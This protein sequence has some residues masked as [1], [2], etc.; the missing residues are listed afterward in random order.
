M[1]VLGFQSYSKRRPSRCHRTLDSTL[2][3]AASATLRP[4]SNVAAQQPPSSISTPSGGSGQNRRP[5]WLVPAPQAIHLPIQP[6]CR[7]SAAEPTASLFRIAA[8]AAARVSP[9]LASVVPFPIILFWPFLF[10]GAIV[11]RFF[12]FLLPVFLRSPDVLT[13]TSQRQKHFDNAAGRILQVDHLHPPARRHDIV[14][15]GDGVLDGRR[16]EEEG[17]AAPRSY[18]DRDD[19]ADRGHNRHLQT[20]RRK[21]LIL[22]SRGRH[23]R[24]DSH[25]WP[26]GES[27]PDLALDRILRG[28]KPGSGSDRKPSVR[29][30]LTP[31]KKSKGDHIQVTETKGTRKASL[32]RRIPLDEA[33]ASREIQLGGEGGE[34]A[35]S[36]TSYASATEESNVS[37]NPIDIEI[38]RNRRRR[39]PASPLIP[40][41][42]TYQPGNPSEISAIPTDSF[43]DGSGP[44]GELKRS[45]SP[46]RVGDGIAAAAAGA[47]AGVAMGEISSN[48]PR[49]KERVKISDSSAK[50][51]SSDRKRRSKSRTSSVSEPVADEI[52]SSRRRS[53]RGHQ[54]STVSAADSSVLS[55]NLSPSH[56]SFDTRS[57]R[58]G[59][60]KSSIN[61]PKLLET[62]EDAIRRLIL[63]ELS[64]LKREQSKREARRGSLTS[65]GTSASRDDVSTDRRRSSGGHRSEH[66]RDPSRHKERRNREARHD[67]DETSLRSASHDSIDAEYRA[68]DGDATTPKRSNN[69]LKVAAAGAAGAAAAKALSSAMDD[70]TDSPDRTQR[71]RRRRRAESARSR[72]LGRDRYSEEYDDED[73]EMAP[74]PPMPLMSDINPSELTRTSILSA[75]TDRPHS[76]SEELV[77]GH[78]AARGLDSPGSTPT[79]ARTPADLQHTLGTKH[80]N[81]S[82]GDLNALP[83]G[84]KGYVQEY[85]TDEFGRK[86][87]IGDYD[88]Y[89]RSRNMPEVDDYPEDDF[90]DRYYSQQDVPP[91]LKYVPYQA[92][93]RGLSP[94]PSVSGYTEGGS[95]AP[96]P[97]SS[98][99]VH[100]PNALPSPGKSPEHGR[101]VR[102]AHS[103]DSVPSNMRSR[104]FDRASGHS[105]NE[106]TAAGQAVRG[107]GANPDFVHPPSGVESA[108]ASLVDGSMLEQ[109]VMTTGSGYDYSGQRDSTIS[110][111]LHSKVDRSSRGISPDKMST[112]S[113]H[114]AGEDMRAATPGSR[115]QAQSQDYSEYD[116]DEHGR[117][118]PRTRYRHSPTASEA[119]ITAG[120]RQA[121]VEDSA[122][123]AF[124]P[125]GVSRNKSFKERTTQHGW[126]PRNT[127]THSVDRL[128]FED[129]PKMAASGIPDMNSPM[130]EIGYMDDDLQTNPSVVEERL[131][132]HRDEH[133][134]SGRATPTQRDIGG[135]DHDG[136]DKGGGLG[137][138]EVAGAAALGAA[139]GM[140]AM[141]HDEPDELDE[142]Q[143]TSEERK[144]DTLVTNPYEDASPI[145]N[146][147]LDET[148]LSGRGLDAQFHTGSPGFGQKY[149]EGYMSNGPV[150]TP[151][152]EPKGK[153]IDFG[154]G[155][156]LGDDP[157]YSPQGHSRHLSGMS[158]GMA[159]PFYDA[160]TGAGIERI[161]NKDIVAL[162]Q[163][164]MVRDAQRSARD[165]EIVALLMN[166]ALEMRNSFRE[167]KELVQDTGD[168]VIFANVENT[169]K[170]Q[171]AIN[172]PRPYPGAA[173]RSIQ[174][175]SQAGTIDDVAA[176]KKNLW[177]RALQ[178]LG[179]KGTSDLSRIEDM[180]PAAA[181]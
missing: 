126:E 112:D 13:S 90:E 21:V 59:A 97:L 169:E 179:A 167:M 78:D 76:A 141:H 3:R 53:S 173:S 10:R 45:A 7:S 42:E 54:E 123:E 24:H 155:A 136:H 102:S 92:G 83:R 105:E 34:D 73:D 178:G 174:S 65:T 113:Y 144:R 5:L 64:A 50:E 12:T 131:D 148:I 51:K 27:L 15:Q 117:K 58:S 82:H 168:D 26:Q 181:W 6:S 114:G 140:A 162:M 134:W 163:H 43:L 91:P 14:D 68:H 49:G 160:A 154:T 80:A 109:S 44:T 85:E 8:S 46:S 124:Q 118:V 125:A 157:F 142:W 95:E 36:M 57:M 75:D 74:A 143:R 116:I 60:S 104:E 107:L 18:R 96:R 41:G 103:Q 175:G 2:P 61:N 180:L 52:R 138:T 56:R 89:E 149:D 130:P 4:S 135:Y 72:S 16:H 133:D 98:R 25:P 84:Q 121:T 161:E 77:S 88:D 110:D 93:A 1:A 156:N 115:S 47:L 81:V 39:R 165:T 71:D 146:P 106:R 37:R 158:Q 111:D 55:S 170:L 28:G 108:V 164:L 127:P 11:S 100:S 66:S 139:A 122:D 63:P 177:R 99:D 150:R 159:S 48:K 172:G 23:A 62:V 145:A 166:A 152:V 9:R 38:D 119:A 20:G 87:P 132:G 17:T 137:I 86:V 32:T 153:A 30:R 69:L 31:S 35:H 101:Y 151:D 147:A 94:I 70:K 40:T 129:Q 33:I 128:D 79:R 176:K 120:E 67:L 19:H 171:K 29:V 22:A